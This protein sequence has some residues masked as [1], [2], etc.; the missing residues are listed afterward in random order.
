MILLNTDTLSKSFGTKELFKNLNISVFENDRIGLIGQNGSGKSTLL[1][2]LSGLEKQ[3]S[4]SFSTKKGLKIG[5]LAQS[6]EFTD[7]PPYEI[8]IDFLKKD[9]T[10]PDYEKDQLVKLW[11][12]KLGFKG[13][14]TS[15]LTL[16][17]GWKKRLD[18]AR[19]MLLSPDLLLLDEPTNHLDLEGIIW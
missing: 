4:G 11:L 9:L 19:Q 13:N 3:D 8:L 1:K 7:K 2:I 18:L 6:S 14:E 16:S 10:T 5:Y 15:A 17:G 12:S